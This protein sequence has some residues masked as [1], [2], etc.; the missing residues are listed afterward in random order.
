MYLPKPYSGNFEIT[1]EFNPERKHPITGEIKPHN[2]IDIAMPEGTIIW[3]PFE[4]KVTAY[5]Q[6]SKDGKSI[7]YGKYIVLTGKTSQGTEILCLF[8]HLSDYLIESGQ[9]VQAGKNIAKSGNSGSSTGSH[10][11]FEI[12]LFDKS[13]NEYIA[14]DPRNYFDFRSDEA[15]KG[16][17]FF[18]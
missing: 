13:K 6:T 17:T 2:G 14:A 5:N 16:G 7:G 15:L 11:H 18:S 12:R 1:S 8:G 9:Y 4:G 10:L 3:A